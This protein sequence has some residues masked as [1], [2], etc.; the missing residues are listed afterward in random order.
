M[1]KIIIAGSRF[2][3]DKKIVLDFLQE[4][5]ETTDLFETEER[6]EVVSGRAKGVDT[7]GEELAIQF[8]WDLIL[9]PADWNKHGRAAGPIRNKQMGDYA[10]V[11][12]AIRGKTENGTPSRGTTHMIEYMTSLGKPVYVKDL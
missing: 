2:V 10:D 3:T 12:I 4:L 6:I 8:G 9:F 1:L 7:I 5:N 11:L